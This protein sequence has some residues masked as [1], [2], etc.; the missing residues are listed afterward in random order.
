[1][2][3][4][5]GYLIDMIK[6]RAIVFTVTNT[7]S[8]SGTLRIK[9]FIPLQTYKND[10]NKQVARYKNFQFLQ[11]FQNHHQKCILAPYEEIQVLSLNL[12]QILNQSK[13]QLQRYSLN[14][15]LSG[16]VQKQLCHFFSKK[17]RLMGTNFITDL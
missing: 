17:N 4:K 11:N 14:L 12:K 6:Q 13:V 2:L 5:L 8:L 15:C 16:D 1:M 10:K 9:Q 3:W 7:L